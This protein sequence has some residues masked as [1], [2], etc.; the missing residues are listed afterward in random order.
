[1]KCRAKSVPFLRETPSSLN[2]DRDL[3]SHASMQE[4]RS[5]RLLRSAE[6]ADARGRKNKG[7][8]FVRI[9]RGSLGEVTKKKEREPASRANKSCDDSV[10]KYGFMLRRNSN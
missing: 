7:D 4:I 2:L 3:L 10:T 8:R 1:M 6:L 9:R 5:D